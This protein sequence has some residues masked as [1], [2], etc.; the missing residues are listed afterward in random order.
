MTN[1][2][3]LRRNIEKDLRSEKDLVTLVPVVKRV[4]EIAANPNFS[5][6][7]MA[8]AIRSDSVLTAKVLRMVNSASFALERKVT[9]VEQAIV[10]LGCEKLGHLCAGIMMAGVMTSRPCVREFDRVG[11]WKHSLGTA[12]AARHIQRTF[13]PDDKLDLFTAGLLCNIGRIILEQRCPE[14]FGQAFRLA[15]EK[16]LF[17]LEAERRTLGATHAEVGAWAAEAW[18]LGGALGQAIRLHHG[19]VG[20]KT[21]DL[22][23]LAYTLA[24]AC[25]IGHPGDPKLLP[26]LPGILKRLA[27]DEAALDDLVQALNKEF[28][29]LEPV[30]RFLETT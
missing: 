22:L 10:M 5:G 13:A 15:Q 24:H 12:V 16:G 14:E 25:R 21:T 11:L 6:E 30:F 28:A 4:R 1:P 19:P 17:L 3:T 27:I 7:E 23:N 2:E 18:R 20:S 29:A 9:D 8:E 26:L